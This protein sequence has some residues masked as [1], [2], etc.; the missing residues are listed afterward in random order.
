[1]LSII[2][3]ARD[4]ERSIEICV[5]SLLAQEWLEFEVI[6]VDDRSTDATPRI[7]ERIACEDTR[8]RVVRGNAQS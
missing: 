7:L 6:V 5:R 4:E 8:L 2:V 1:M 3:P